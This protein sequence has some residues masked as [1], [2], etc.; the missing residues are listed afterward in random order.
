M[1]E[2]IGGWDRGDRRRKEGRGTAA[3][4][5]R[6]MCTVPCSNR[7]SYRRFFAVS[8]QS[9]CSTTGRDAGNHESAALGTRSPNGERVYMFRRFV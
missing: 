3:A 6:A 1:A 9:A 2:R 7:R 4:G 8:T 5:G